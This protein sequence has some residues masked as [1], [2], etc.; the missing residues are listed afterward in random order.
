MAQKFIGAEVRAGQFTD[1]A[2]GKL[3]SYN[4]LKFQVADETAG[5]CGIIC[6]KPFIKIKNT[7]EEILRVFGEPISMQWLKDR[8]GWWCDVYYDLNNK[9]SRIMFIGP[10][11]P[12]EDTPAEEKRTPEGIEDYEHDDSDYPFDDSDIATEK[13]GV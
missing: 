3:V 1:K 8:L 2:T 4:N 9:L 13:E 12:A 7:R 10:E 11:K 6:Q 5:D